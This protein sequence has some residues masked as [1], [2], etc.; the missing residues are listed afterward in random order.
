MCSS[1]ERLRQQ[2][3]TRWTS[4]IGWNLNIS[5]KQ[6]CNSNFLKCLYCKIYFIVLYLGD[7]VFSLVW[8][9][10]IDSQGVK[11]DF[12][13]TNFGI[14]KSPIKWFVNEGQHSSLSLQTGAN[15]SEDGIEKVF[16]AFN[17]SPLL[18]PTF[19]QPTG[20]LCFN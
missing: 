3:F 1:S 2:Y 18:N 8:L 13:V 20:S 10:I 5:R 16:P 4:L 15:Q 17:P 12:F 9:C 19:N 7:S 6:H 14:V 11:T